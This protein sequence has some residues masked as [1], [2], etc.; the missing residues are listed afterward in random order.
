MVINCFC[1]RVD[2]QVFGGDDGH[3][4]VLINNDGL[5]MGYQRVGSTI[6]LLLWEGRC[7]IIC[8]RMQAEMGHGP[9]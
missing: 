4:F 2:R 3:P 1:L 8:G 7:S 9:G 6:H 5:D